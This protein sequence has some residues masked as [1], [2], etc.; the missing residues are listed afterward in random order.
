MTDDKFNAIRCRQRDLPAPR[1][2][3]SAQHEGLASAET[4]PPA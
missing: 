4:D 3:R 2:I 1:Q